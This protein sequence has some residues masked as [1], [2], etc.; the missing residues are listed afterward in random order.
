M[1]AIVLIGIGMLVDG[2]YF[3]SLWRSEARATFG[4][5]ILQLQIGDAASGRRLETGQAF[6]RW[7]ALA[8]W[9]TIAGSSTAIGGASGVIGLVWLLWALILLLTTVSSPTKQGLHDRFAETAV[10]RQVGSS[11]SLVVGCLV[12]VVLLFGALALAVVLSFG[13]LAALGGAS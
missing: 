2:A 9:L 5:R 7:V 1:R 6:R 4:M 13:V 11:N 8:S 3:I 12:I 10:V